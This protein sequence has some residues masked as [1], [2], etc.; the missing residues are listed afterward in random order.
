VPFVPF[1][2]DGPGSGR[3]ILASESVMLLCQTCQHR[4]DANVELLPDD[5]SLALVAS[6]FVCPQCQRGGAYV[7]PSWN[8]AIRQHND[9]NA[10]KPADVESGPSD[11]G[12]N[13]QLSQKT[14]ETPAPQRLLLSSAFS[15]QLWINSEIGF[16][17]AG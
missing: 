3:A 13:N 6:K 11:N 14:P 16:S 5:T 2:S 12:D 4:Q 15:G 1:P 17:G 9:S 7:L 10:T 8:A